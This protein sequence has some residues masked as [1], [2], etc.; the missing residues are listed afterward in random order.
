MNK[1][2]STAV[3]IALY[4]TTSGMRWCWKIM[5]LFP[6][7]SR[8]LYTKLYNDICLAAD[9]ENGQDEFSSVRL[10]SLCDAISPFGI[11]INSPGCDQTLSAH[12]FTA[13]SSNFRLI[14]C[15]NSCLKKPPQKLWNLLFTIFSDLSLWFCWNL[16]VELKSDLFL[17]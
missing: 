17:K 1:F 7:L 9:E 3:K 8:L 2:K 15:C 6:Y 4:I 13:Q 11:L 12:A 16:D 14:N 5:R 10:Q